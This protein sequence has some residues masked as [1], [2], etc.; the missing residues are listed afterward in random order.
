MAGE[1]RTTDRTF[2]YTIED[3][4]K[5]LER[6]GDYRGDVKKPVVTKVETP[7]RSVI[8]LDTIFGLPPQGFEANPGTSG[9][10]MDTLPIVEIIPHVPQIAGSV[11]PGP[12]FYHP[13]TPA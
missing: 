8:E 13:L 1:I 3:I 11:Q 7:R 10:M 2:H 5:E 9:L 4:D 12:F 6:I